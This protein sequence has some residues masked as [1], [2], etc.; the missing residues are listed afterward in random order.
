MEDVALTGRRFTGHELPAED[1]LAFVQ[2]GI[3]QIPRKYDVRVLVRAPRD[4]V[5]AVTG[6]WAELTE[7]D[8]GTLMAMP[9]DDLFWPLAVLASIDADF[10]VEGPDELRE[11]VASVSRRFRGS[12]GAPA[13]ARS[14]RTTP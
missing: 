9:T 1:A 8:G 12:R 2:A 14:P 4:E 11:Q 7:A 10:E 13:R 6:R 3:R 5:A